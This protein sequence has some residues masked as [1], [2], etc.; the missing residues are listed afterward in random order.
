[1]MRALQLTHGA[2]DANSNGI[3]GITQLM[4]RPRTGD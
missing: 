4:E 3:G 2:A 1:V